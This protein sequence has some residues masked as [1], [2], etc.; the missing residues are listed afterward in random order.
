MVPQEI[1]PTT[2]LI[3]ENMKLIMVQNKNNYKM[4]Q[5]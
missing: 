3:E 4:K 2:H 1:Q 5:K